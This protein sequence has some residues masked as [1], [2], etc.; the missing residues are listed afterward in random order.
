[1]LYVHNYVW[2]LIS[3]R[4]KPKLGYEYYTLRMIICRGQQLGPKCIYSTHT[5]VY[6]SA[7]INTQV[8]CIDT[9]AN[10]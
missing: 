3:P 7:D 4:G 5:F 9:N 10:L 6:I 8:L 2:G 1:M